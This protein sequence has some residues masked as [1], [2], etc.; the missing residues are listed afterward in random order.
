M[1]K[2]L[3]L[4]NV[5]VG[6]SFELMI[7]EVVIIELWRLQTQDTGEDEGSYED[8][9]NQDHGGNRTNCAQ[10]RDVMNAHLKNICK[11]RYYQQQEC[12]T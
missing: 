5:G 6:I 2:F 11:V 1:L 4:V 8:Q 12:L 10:F 3:K 9:D 7:E